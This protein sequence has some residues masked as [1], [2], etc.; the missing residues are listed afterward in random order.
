MPD[1]ELN[2]WVVGDDAGRVFPVEIKETKT[3]GALKEVIKEKKKP[4]FDSIPAD[5]LDLW[6]VSDFATSCFAPTTRNP[7]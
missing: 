7:Q 4:V 2:C 1:L 6:K 3:V 5:V